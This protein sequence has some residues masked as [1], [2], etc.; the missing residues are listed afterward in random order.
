MPPNPIVVSKIAR[1]LTFTRATAPTQQTIVEGLIAK[2]GKP[3][4]EH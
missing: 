4:Y 1:V 2:Y 3:S